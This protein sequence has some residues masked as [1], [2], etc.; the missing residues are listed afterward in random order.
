M[1]PNFS[2]WR[3]IKEGD[4]MDEKI[5]W[6]VIDY[7]LGGIIAMVS[8]TDYPTLYGELAAAKG[9]VNALWIA[10]INGNH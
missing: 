10:A 1:S 9:D 4:T 6:Q 2:P 3:R 8:Q 5:K 7:M